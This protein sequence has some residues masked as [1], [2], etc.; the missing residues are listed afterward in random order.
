MWRWY[1]REFRE[2]TARVLAWVLHAIARHHCI[3]ESSSLTQG[4]S[5]DSPQ[6]SPKHQL[7]QRVKRVPIG[8]P[9][10]SD[11]IEGRGLADVC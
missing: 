9:P 2:S 5:G 1:Q 4:R 10:Q 11:R 6:H 7:V 3:I 8:S